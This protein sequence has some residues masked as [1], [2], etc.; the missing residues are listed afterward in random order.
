MQQ[1]WC[2]AGTQR[3][4]SRMLRIGGALA[5]ALLL[6]LA[7]GCRNGDPAPAA[8]GV[9]SADAGLANPP[10]PTP[11][12]EPI[13]P[14]DPAEVVGAGAACAPPR[15]NA[16]CSGDDMWARNPQ[17]G[18][19]C[20]YSAPCAVPWNWPMFES[21]SECE[22]S[23]RCADV[24]PI[25]V[26]LV[27]INELTPAIERTSFECFC[28][29][30]SCRTEET[31]DEVVGSLCAAGGE[32]GTTM[33]RGCGMVVI[34]SSGGYV[35]GDRVFDRDTGA[36]IG[37]TRWSDT[38]IRPCWAY[39]IVIGREF[40]CEGATECALCAGDAGATSGGLPACD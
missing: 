16:Y 40:V 25:D 37:R 34:R 21:E 1:S 20:L 9:P 33:L 19:C 14:A 4:G 23:C 8:V 2:N 3:R 32:S 7:L 12:S 10:E 22:T 38:P 13:S 36:L 28:P 24:T 30:G 31:L 6:A 15:E 26:S 11:S 35:G 27:E 29:D 39:S 18:E 17:T 5:Q